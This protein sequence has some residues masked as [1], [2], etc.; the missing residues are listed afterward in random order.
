MLNR[1]S[2][3][4]VML[5][6]LV[7]ASG[8]ARAQTAVE[9]DEAKRIRDSIT[10]FT[11]IMMAEDSAIPRSILSKA[12]GIAIFPDT[13]KAGFVVGGTHGRGILSAHDQNG[14]SAPSFLTLT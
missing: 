8:A 13:L 1:F 14:W 9:S 12:E 6:V 2:T 3:A 4:A 10:V 7:L 11:E 5:V